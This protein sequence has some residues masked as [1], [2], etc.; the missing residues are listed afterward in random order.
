MVTLSERIDVLLENAD[1]LRAEIK[2]LC[3]EVNRRD[4]IESID[5]LADVPGELGN[6]ESLADQLCDYLESA[7]ICAKMGG[8]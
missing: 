8:D 2:K 6:A 4:G 7:E 3:R 5:H 1:Q